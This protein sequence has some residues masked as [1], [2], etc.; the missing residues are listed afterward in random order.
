MP[1]APCRQPCK[2]FERF[3]FAPRLSWILRGVL[4]EPQ[5]RGSLD[6][7]ANFRP[8]ARKTQVMNA[9]QIAP[10]PRADEITLESEQVAGE[11]SYIVQV[12]VNCEECGGSGFDPGGIDPWG[13]E[14]CPVCHGARTLRIVRNYLAEAFQIAA[15]PNSTRQV[16]RQHLVAIVQHCRE[17]VIAS[18]GLADVAWDRDDGE[19]V[20][21]KGVGRADFL[22]LGALVQGVYML[23]SRNA[24]EQ[25]GW[26]CSRCRPRKRLEIHHREYRSH[27]GTHRIENLEPVCRDCHRLIHR[28]ERSLTQWSYMRAFGER[29]SSTR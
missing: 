6:L 22:A 8:R 9:E 18:I 14:T 17:M 13:P 16:E 15:N 21:V 25:H 5:L 28:T 2:P 24:M 23:H 11:P 20:V 19:K 3:R 26:R 29:S 7:R 27:G 12:Q 1:L 10:Q 4:Q